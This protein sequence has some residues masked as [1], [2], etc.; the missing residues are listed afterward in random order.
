MPKGYWVGRVDVKPEGYQ[1]YGVAL[2]EMLRKYGRNFW[3]AAS[4]S[5]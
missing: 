1:A 2:A 4:T 3:C 5:L